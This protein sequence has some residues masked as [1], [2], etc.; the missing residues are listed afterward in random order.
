M[1]KPEIVTGDDV[2]LLQQLT[3]YN[4]DTGVQEV[5]N[6]PNSATVTSRIISTDHNE[7]YSDEVVQS[8]STS[9]AD[10]VN[11]LVAVSF[12]TTQTSKVINSSAPWKSGRVNAKIETQVDDNGKLTF[13]A[14]VI[15]VKGTIL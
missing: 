1:N 5:F 13:F 10:W 9:G 6:I 14:S 15:M 3:K 11:S 8:D 2:V 7:S 12:D 4:K